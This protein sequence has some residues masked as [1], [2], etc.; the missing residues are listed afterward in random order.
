MSLLKKLI[1]VKFNKIEKLITL[2]YIFFNKRYIPT[3]V[4][5]IKRYIP[6][7]YKSIPTSYKPR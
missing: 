4:G 7:R 5:V 1:P 2:D 6:V 3:K